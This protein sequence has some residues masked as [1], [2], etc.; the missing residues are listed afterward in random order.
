MVYSGVF[1]FSKENGCESISFLVI[2]ARL[3]SE[4]YETGWAGAIWLAR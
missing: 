3:S 1:T 4:Y 2:L